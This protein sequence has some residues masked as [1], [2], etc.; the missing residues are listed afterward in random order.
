M[1]RQS[2]RKRVPSARAEAAAAAATAK[3]AAKKPKKVKK[4]LA[5]LAARKSDAAAKK[6]KDD[7]AMAPAVNSDNEAGTTGNDTI[8]LLYAERQKRKKEKKKAKT[9]E[10]PDSEPSSLSKAPSAKVKAEPK[11]E[12]TGYRKDNRTNKDDTQWMYELVS[13]RQSLKFLDQPIEDDKGKCS[14]MFDWLNF[15]TTPKQNKYINTTRKSK[16]V[17]EGR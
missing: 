3:A 8:E 7:A 2:S 15:T 1:T 16:Y 5:S 12:Q 13:A 11:P 6:A 4:T 10:S 9:P 17:P 14:N